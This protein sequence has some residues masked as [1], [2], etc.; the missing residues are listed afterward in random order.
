[1]YVTGRGAIGSPDQNSTA[2]SGFS[3]DPATGA[4]TRITDSG[5]SSSQNLPMGTLASP[6]GNALFLFTSIVGQAPG[7]DVVQFLGIDRATG[8]LSEFPKGKI[9]ANFQMRAAIHPSSRFLYLAYRNYNAPSIGAYGIDE[10][11]GTLTP[12]AGQ[13]FAVQTPGQLV[14]EPGG[15]FLYIFSD[16]TI[17]AVRIDQQ[18]GALSRVTG[19]PITVRP[20]Q[21][22]PGRLTLTLTGVIDPVGDFLFTLDTANSGVIWVYR[23]DKTT[24]ALLLMPGSPFPARSA[25]GGQVDPTGRFLYLVDWYFDTIGEFAID[26]STGALTSI[27]G[28]P[29][30][31]PTWSPSGPSGG[32][33]VADPSGKFLYFMDNVTQNSLTQLLGYSIDQSTGSLT[34]LPSS[35]TSMDFSGDIVITH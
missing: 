27:P 23:I 34:A 25:Y 14:A 7:T 1:M 9:T 32:V 19:F 6:D 18:T 2:I 30:Q 21:S 26:R 20:S 17:D 3:I 28:S 15:N 11:G 13:P 12:I 5:F 35:P 4:V 29:V 10:N 16:H 33:V 8:K 24:G 31:P 22:S